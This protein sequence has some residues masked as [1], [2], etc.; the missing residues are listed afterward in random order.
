MTLKSYD[1]LMLTVVFMCV[2]GPLLLMVVGELGHIRDWR[3]GW[4]R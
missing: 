2:A 3:M 4:H 1:M